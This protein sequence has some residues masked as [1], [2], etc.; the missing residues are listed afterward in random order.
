MTAAMR[1]PD[2]RGKFL[3][4]ASSGKGIHVGSDGKQGFGSEEVRPALEETQGP[5]RW[6]QDS[7]GPFFLGP[8]HWICSGLDSFRFYPVP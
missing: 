4:T 5:M 7:L 6:S 8:S 1:Y 3:V 2:G